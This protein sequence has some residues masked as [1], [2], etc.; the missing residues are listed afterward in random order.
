M[1]TFFARFIVPVPCILIGS[2]AFAVSAAP[3]KTVPFQQ[4]WLVADSLIGAGLT[5]SALD[6]VNRIYKQAK[7]TDNQV[8]AIKAIIY[9]MRLE[10]YGEEDAYI[11]TL[12]KLNEEIKDS[13]FPATPLLHSMLAECYL[14]YYQNNR[15]R[16]YNRTQTTNFDIADIHTWDLHTILEKTASEYEL[17]LKDPSNLKKIIHDAFD[18]LISDGNLDWKL[19]PTLYDFLVNRAIDFYSMDDNELT[20]PAIEFT[21]N[22]VNYFASFDK[23]MQLSIT[24]P[25]SSSLKFHALKLLQNVIAFHANN[26]DIEALIDSDLQ[27]L[28]FVRQHAVMANKDSL[29]LTALIPLANLAPYC[30]ASAEADYH[31]A[32]LYRAWANSYSTSNNERYR[33][34]NKEA[35]ALCNKTMETYPKSFG[36]ALCKKLVSEITV[37]SMAFTSE[38]VNLPG[39]PFKALVT[40]KNVNRVYWRQIK[41]GSGNYQAMFNQP[42]YDYDSIVIKLAKIKPVKEW[43]TAVPDPND[44]QDH[45]VEIEMPALPLGQYALLCASDSSFS[46]TKQT[47]AF[48]SLQISRISYINRQI[49]PTK[50]EFHILDRETGAPLKGVSVK[51]WQRAHDEK[52]SGYKK[53]SQGTFLSDKEG[54]VVVPISDNSRYDPNRTIDCFKN[55]DSLYSNQENYYYEKQAQITLPRTYFFTDR[56]MYRPGQTIYFKGIMLRTNG[57][58][59]EITAGQNTNVSFFNVNNQ[60]VAQLALTSNK[61]G[62]IHGSFIA[63]VSSLNGRMR[64]RNDNGSI[65]FSVEDYKRPRFEVTMDPFKGE[66]R[67]GDTIHATGQAKGYSGAPIDGAKTKYRVKRI[68]HIPYYLSWHPTN[69]SSQTDICSGNKVTNDTGGFSIDFT[70][71]PDPS[72]PQSGN[73]IFSY[74][75]SI[76][77]TDIN[78]E[79][80]STSSTINVGYATLKLDVTV[81]KQIKQEA[82]IS[83]PLTTV[84]LNGTFEPAQ[85]TIVIH[86]LKSPEKILRNRL[87]ARPDTTIISQTDYQSKFSEDVFNNENDIATWQKENKVFEGNFDTKT[88]KTIKLPGAIHWK[89]GCYVLEGRTRDK[90]G[91]EVTDINYFTLF[92]ENEKALPYPQTDWFVP[93]KTTCEPGDKAVFLVGSAYSNVKMLYELDY[94]NEIV[95]KE[96]LS[97]N[98]E[99]KR[100]EFPIEEK[101]RGNLSF[102]VAFVHCN[103]GYENSAI[104]NVPWT[105]KELD[106]SFETFRNKL[107]PGEH[108]EWRMKIAGKNKDK[109]AAEMVATLY[110]ASLDAFTPH[111]WD[112][113]IYPLFGVGQAWNVQEVTQTK[114]AMFCEHDW[115]IYVLGLRRLYPSFN[116]FRYGFEGSTWDYATIYR[117]NKL[118]SQPSELSRK[119]PELKSAQPSIPGA[120]VDDIIGGLLDGK[121]EAGIGY[122]GGYGGGFGAPEE[123]VLNKGNKEP[124][125]PDLTQV[126]ARANLNETAFFYPDLQTN[127]KG[128]I[129]VK[130]QIPE[131][132]TKWKMLGF[133]HTK[134]LCFGQITKELVTQKDLMVVPNPPRFFRENDKITF[135]AKVSNLSDSVLSGNAQLF[136][137]DAAS[138]KPVDSLFKN[139]TAQIP[140]TARKGQSTAL[141]WDLS[142]PEGIGAVTCK[143][144][145]KSGSFSDGEEHIVP[146]LSNRMLVTESMPL[147]IR[148]NET[149]SFTFSN[150]LSQNNNSKTLKNHALTLEF[151]TNP[152]WY[153]VQALP[154]LMEYPY[155]C[156]E[157]TFA[158][159]YANSIAAHIA[160]SSPHIK[161]VFDQWKMQSPDALL[162]NLEK[163]QELKAL[164]LEE[165]PWLLDGKNESERKN[166]VALL[167]DLNKLANEK[168]R[169]LA[170]LRKL[171]MSDGAWPWFEGGPDDRY[172]TQYIA[173]GLWP[174]W[175][176]WA[177][178]K[179]VTVRGK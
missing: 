47:V 173:T 136:L 98:N 75:I 65:A 21:L 167:F 78:G 42:N 79:T 156:A 83:F 6:T 149:K 125:K 3:P 40:Y 110:D 153:A 67:L 9:R 117:E 55:D 43:N 81:G 164:M 151:T 35:L 69:W 129:I 49:S 20:K 86:R 165:T 140:F 100:L 12:N 14:H 168:E 80:R 139:T 39:K 51:A 27:R 60:E 48:G 72:I 87:W 112:F 119:K 170:K 2:L 63:P 120:R 53:V 95:K 84:N 70:A 37:K 126:A 91:Q 175:N 116:W 93:V 44:Y 11:K 5:Q 50:Y 97:I 128:E 25:D 133:A 8:Q 7:S 104:V 92:S 4:S 127:E 76:D 124:P 158:R 88:D 122:G 152:V 145:A 166:R 105:N 94:K 58:K 177:C 142:V 90:F 45:S 134:D 36:A 59:S 32:S 16:F 157:Q 89:P 15:G 68:A 172:I 77:V 101:H 111:N 141:L 113:S 99:Q 61:Y 28:S 171:Q 34:M 1:K 19:R 103:R 176:I 56:A 115:N 29:Y 132:L 30:P 107:T 17:S 13:K 54:T 23:F 161:A 138:M 62:S 85:G 108:E 18:A 22:N 109:I 38:S 71:L 160:N 137:F 41:I 159:F 26:N 46:C 102:N 148:K 74:V 106:I 33:W 66:N 144:V 123:S 24:T 162:S 10:S 154:Y 64:I 31:I 163:N 52:S 73:L 179:H 147:H 131:A 121:G 96:W 155:E 169:S 150:L 82:E 174:S 114:T 135:S 118:R 57:D 130:F 178:L 146:V 143:V